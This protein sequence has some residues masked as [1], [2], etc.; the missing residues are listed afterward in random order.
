MQ[1]I[2][3][4]LL[5]AL[6][7]LAIPIIIHLFYFRRY[8]Q[9]YFTNVR[10]LKE[11]VE[12]TSHRNRLRNILILTSRILA[13]SALIIAF[14]QPFLKNQNNVHIHH[15]AV[16][17]FIDNSW[18][19]N[20]EASDGSLF[21]KAK[22]SALDIIQAYSEFDKF[23]IV[24]HELSGNQTRI[25]SKPE[26]L[27]A[28]ELIKQSSTVNLLSKVVRKQQQFLQG[29][30]GFDK[31]IFIISDFQKS[32]TDLSTGTI[33]SNILFNLVPLQGINENNIAIDT[34]YFL[35]P[36]L[37]KGQS[38]K[39]IYEVQNYGNSNVENLKLS[40]KIN[41]Q[42]YP[43]SGINI[44]AKKKYLDTLN[45]TFANS[46]SQKLILKI[47]DYPIQFDDQYFMAFPVEENIKVLIIYNK[48]P[49]LHL[50]Q[51]LS[52][53]SNFNT[54]VQEVG[55]LDY[56]SFSKYKLIILND[57][58]NISTGFA[59]ELSK[60][61]KNGSNLF[62]FPAENLK[63]AYSSL[64][65]S[66]KFPKFK[67]FY[68]LKKEVGNIQFESGIFDDVF[69][70][71]KANMKLPFV[72]SSYQIANSTY[73]EALLNF[74]D[75]SPYISRYPLDNSFIY[76]C[77]SSSDPEI[78]S[79]A[80]NVEIFIPILFKAAISGKNSNAYSYTIGQV[81]IISWPI[82]EDIVTKE[83]TLHFKGPDDFIT[84]AKLSQGQFKIELFDQLKTAGIYDVLNQETLLGSLA[85]NENRIESKL[86]FYNLESLKSTFGDR[87]N[88]INPDQV[89]NLTASIQDSKD[90]QSLWWFLILA[91]IVF[92]L[93]ESI[94]IRF[95]KNS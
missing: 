19:M 90:K 35:N 73:S 58:P 33:D 8:K 56:S 53:I 39:L 9:V 92:L 83:N 82:K 28:I 95:W 23:Q 18:S 38:N 77:S 55:A 22:K 50:M 31:E 37:L 87:I 89:G 80:K 2:F 93:I 24:S 44:P 64:E 14:A 17:L 61:V 68:S 26:A 47:A 52:A 4:G 46:G 57:L 48:K 21:T 65:A 62:I 81:S 79:L 43:I 27:T 6:G 70:T 60:S 11:L 63:E 30:D 78:N 76:Y 25:Y 84:S 49:P 94:L 16:S 13:F 40:Y 20:S 34:A 59:S 88:I 66:I 5:W 12:E 45:L 1:F 36:V 69:M 54:Q 41:G 51:S 15:K 3:P 75:G 72:M 86:D 29:M 91:G 85:F 71:R 10:L 42:E 32:I 74:K 7:L 67:D